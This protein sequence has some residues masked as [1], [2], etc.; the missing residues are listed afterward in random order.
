[1]ILAAARP[2]T[3][4]PGF[5]EGIFRCRTPPPSWRR[6]CCWRAGGLA[7]DN[8]R[9]NILDACAA[10]GGKTA[11]LLEL[12]DCE[13]T[14][15]DIDARRCERV[16]RTCSAWACKAEVRAAMPASPMPGGTAG[17]S[18]ASCWTRPAPPPASCG[19]TP[20]CA[21]CAGP[22]TSPSWPPSRR[23][24][25][26]RCGPAQAG[27]APA[28]LHLLGFPGRRRQPD[29][30]VS[31]APHRCPIKALAGAFA[32]PK[33]GEA[34]VFPDNLM[35]EHD[36]FYYALLEKSVPLTAVSAGG[37]RC[38]L[39]V[40]CCLCVLLACWRPGQ[41]RPPRSRSCA[42]SAAKTACTCRP[43]CV[44]PAAGGGRRPAQGHPDVFCGRGRHLPRPLVLDRPARGQR[45]PHHAPG[46]PAADAPLARQH[47]V[48]ADHQLL[49][50]AGHA[51]PELRNPA[52]GLVG[53]AARL[54]LEDRR[55][56][57]VDPDASHKLEFSFRLD[58]RNCRGRSRSAPPASGTGISPRRPRIG[59]G[60]NPPRPRPQPRPQ[61][62][63]PPSEPAGQRRVP[64]KQ[65]GL[66]L[67]G[68]CRHRRHRGARH[69]A[70]V[71]ADAGHRQPRT[72][73]TQLRRCCWCSTWWSPACCCW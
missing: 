31:Y 60:W 39:A 44:R 70:D 41:L 49:R 24:C 50:L 2:V 22:A 14:A 8:A 52:R 64:Q 69:G 12:A 40:G 55:A 3:G 33:W 66:S 61:A 20:T 42:W 65:Q 46:L 23:S 13:V 6:L 34:T 32:A 19:A 7:G 53:G 26:K 58:C 17:C 29:T 21:G 18:T 27:R 1:V 72:L 30:N 73:R 37:C 43:W 10:P 5:A 51:E 15:L 36:G 38:A 67:D 71:P 45:R 62:P 16:A 56:G 35:R 9:L 57:D 47:R 28:V 25:W 11:H 63:R 59:S 68:R 54:P 4:L 48:R